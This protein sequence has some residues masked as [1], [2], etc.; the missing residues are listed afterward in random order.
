M[1]AGARQQ[2][3]ALEHEA[4]APAADARQRRLI[5]LR[6][7]DALEQVVAAGRA[8]EAAEDVHQRRLA[9]TGGAHDGDELA[10][11]NGEA[12]AA[13]RVHLGVAQPIDLG[14]I[15]HDDD[16]LA[17]LP[18]GPRRARSWRKN[19]PPCGR[20]LGLLVPGGRSPPAVGLRALGARR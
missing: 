13:Q 2:I 10:A 14:H 18:P 7:V 17:G 6:D 5:Q 15:A 1:R 3:E 20:G 8:I 12:H 16:R 4:D 11:V 9:R 19:P